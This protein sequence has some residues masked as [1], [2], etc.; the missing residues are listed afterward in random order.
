MNYSYNIISNFL[1]TL[2]IGVVYASCGSDELI[3]LEKRSIRLMDQ[4]SNIYIKKLLVLVMEYRL[5][6]FT[7][8]S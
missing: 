2:I 4:E 7:T 6:I 1:C 5:F 3:D 8:L